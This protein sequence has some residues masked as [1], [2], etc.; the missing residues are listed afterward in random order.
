MLD[1]GKAVFALRAAMNAAG[2]NDSQ[3]RADLL[4]FFCNEWND[5]IRAAMKDRA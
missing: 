4:G 2:I 3:L 5:A 1:A